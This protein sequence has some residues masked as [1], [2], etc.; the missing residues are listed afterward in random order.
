MMVNNNIRGLTCLLFMVVNAYSAVTIPPERQIDAK[1][2]RHITCPADQPLTMPTDVVLDSRNRLY[3]ADGVNDRVI[4]F[5]ADGKVDKIIAQPGNTKLNQPVGLGIDHKDQLWIADTGN[6]RIVVVSSDGKML[7]NIQLPVSDQDRPADP[8]DI[9]VTTDGKRAYI[10]DNN[11][12]RLLIRENASG[13]WKILGRKGRGLGQF[14]Y[15]FLACIGIEDYFYVV[16][17]MGSRIQRISPS[18]RW[19]GLIGSWGVELGQLYR[20]KGIAADIKGNIYV[21]DSVL[22]VIQVFG[23]WGRIKG[24][25][26][27]DQGQPL[28]FVRVERV[29]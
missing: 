20:P 22:Q 7:Q 21:S 16:E 25:L 23:P 12:N 14:E 28:R 29:T 6:H 27:N 2:V 11:N 3:V 26:C 10:V 17:V 13:K 1:V 4:R 9:A 5:T 15:P 24:V 8:T 19:S 18:D